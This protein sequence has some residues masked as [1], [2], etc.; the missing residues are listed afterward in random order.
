MVVCFEA[1]LHGDRVKTLHQRLALFTRESH[2]PESNSIMIR[3]S[4]W[5]L[6]TRLPPD[7][8]TSP[9]ELRKVIYAQDR[10]DSTV[11]YMDVFPLHG[12]SQP[13]AITGVP[14]QIHQ[15]NLAVCGSSLMHHC[16]L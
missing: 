11:G 10:S 14:R 5:I 12:S 6:P 2:L 4:L 3:S 13:R 1:C 15:E 7:S 8:R 9:P 16:V